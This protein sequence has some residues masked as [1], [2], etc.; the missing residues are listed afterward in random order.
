L[1]YNFSLSADGLSVNCENL[2]ILSCIKLRINYNRNSNVIYVPDLIETNENITT[3]TFKRETERD[4]MWEAEFTKLIFTELDGALITKADFACRYDS[5]AFNYT[6]QPYES[7]FLDFKLPENTDEM[8]CLENEVPFWLTPAFSADIPSYAEIES[9]AYKCHNMHTH[10]LPLVNEDT[11]TRIKNSSVTI[12]T[13]VPNQTKICSNIFVISCESN[14]FN[15]IEACVSAGRKT[16]AIK[17][18]PRANRKY[19]KQLEGFGWCTWNAF[20]KDVTSNGIYEKLEELKTK[21]VS[22]KWLLVDDG[23]QQYTED[24]KLLSFKED[25][26]KFPEGFKTFV[27]RAKNN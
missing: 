21:G 13:N 11:R 24:R 17:A 25:P 14:P 8:L 26:K 3:V 10:I 5:F 23:W 7:V 1:K 20:Y 27:S 16:D 12:S 4:W 15:A 9:L 18:S 19:P 6:Y 2:T 22:L